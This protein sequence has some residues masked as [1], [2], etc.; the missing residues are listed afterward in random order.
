[1]QPPEHH[2]GYPIVFESLASIG[3]HLK[4]I[5]GKAGRCLVVTDTHV[6]PLHGERLQRALQ[7]VGW[8]PQV[9]A[10]DPGEESKSTQTLD[11][12][13]EWA[14][15]LEVERATA[16]LAFGGGVVGDLTGY[17]AATLLRGVPLVQVPTTLVAQVDSSIG[18]K[19]GINH[20]RGKNLIGAFYRPKLVLS[21]VSLLH[22]L[23]EDDWLSGLSE[24]I[25]HAL[26][27]DSGL[28]SDLS[29]DW[30]NVLTRRSENLVDLVSR[31]ASVKIRTVAQ[32]EFES[33]IRMHLN[34]GHTFGHAIEQVAGYGV[35]SH[36]RA[37]AAGMA[38]ATFLS[39]RYTDNLAVDTILEPLA[40][41]CPP[42]WRKLDAARIV[43]AMTND[44]KRSDGRT[45]FVL[46]RQ[47]G[48][49]YVTADVDPRLVLESIH[50]AQQ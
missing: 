17:F 20:P 31:S 1:M 40:A 50:R 30:A 3:I 7:S 35:I 13:Y 28:F 39:A 10:V 34:F 46:L 18:G 26:I 49:A 4:N 43:E 22:T 42:D 32:D 15:S 48:D 33:G 16:V 41:L 24:T 45:R 11:D 38:A 12:L 37:V 5:L 14:L 44:K 25:K 29:E 8:E 23:S 2:V 47:P 27:A 21:D 19:T 9:R 36:G 6:W